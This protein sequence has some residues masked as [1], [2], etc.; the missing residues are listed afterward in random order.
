MVQHAADSVPRTRKCPAKHGQG[1]A[2]ELAVRGADPLQQ[3]LPVHVLILILIVG[4]GDAQRGRPLH[5]LDTGHLFRQRL[6]Q[7]ELPYRQETGLGQV[8]ALPRG[9]PKY[10]HSLQELLHRRLLHIAQ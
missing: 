9:P 3:W 10:L 6:H 1:Q 4:E 8:E 7:A 2:T 5:H